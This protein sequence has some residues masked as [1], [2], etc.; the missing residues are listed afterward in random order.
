MVVLLAYFLGLKREDVARLDVPLGILYM[1]EP[2][3]YG[4]EFKAYKYNR[5]TDWFDH[6]EDFQLKNEDNRDVTPTKY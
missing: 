5:E 2:K 1:L 6:M 3:P 4:V